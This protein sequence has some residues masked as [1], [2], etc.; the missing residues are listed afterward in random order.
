MESIAV[1]WE[2]VVR[3]YGFEIH[4]G[5]VLVKLEYPQQNGELLMEHLG[6]DEKFGTSFL[7]SQIQLTSPGTAS[8][9]I[10]L[11]REHADLFLSQLDSTTGQELVISVVV[12][13]PVD[14]L[15]FHGPHFQDRYGIAD[16]AFNSLDHSQV[17][18]HA[19]GC[20]GTSVYIMADGGQG[21]LVRGM[22]SDAFTVPKEHRKKKP[23]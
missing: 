8:M 7:F 18:I 3:V 2:P 13:Q 17:T 23:E 1:Y 20:T 16:T 11:R 15:F 21:E 9:N 6:S 4:S 22:L 10:A 5:A 12:H 14:L 19:V